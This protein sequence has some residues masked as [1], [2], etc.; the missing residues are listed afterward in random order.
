MTKKNDNK[1]LSP[2]R[3]PQQQRS[4]QT[5]QKILDA[6]LEIVEIQGI[7]SLSTRRIASTADIA[8]ASIYQYFPN[9]EAIIDALLQRWYDGIT[10]V[11][12]SYDDEKYYKLGWENFFKKMDE[13]YLSISETN[14]TYQMLFNHVVTNKSSIESAEK[15]LQETCDSYVK[16]LKRFGSTWSDKALEDAVLVTMHCFDAVMGNMYFENPDRNEQV[17]KHV[18]TMYLSLWEKTITTDGP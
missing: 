2:R 13:D 8:F 6:A 4:Q 12:N 10:A 7:A 14:K 15:H 11:I 3:K 18:Q 5:K 16:F 1:T 17:F 9:K